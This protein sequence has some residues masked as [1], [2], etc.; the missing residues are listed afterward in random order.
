M[1][2]KLQQE[3]IYEVSLKTAEAVINLRNSLLTL[4]LSRGLMTNKK[5]YITVLTVSTLMIDLFARTRGLGW[6]IQVF[7]RDA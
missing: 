5:G 7:F 6:L 1:R 2:D 4:D 3:S